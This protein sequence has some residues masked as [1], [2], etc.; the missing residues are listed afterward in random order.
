MIQAKKQPPKDVPQK[1]GGTM[2]P[3][4]GR[5]LQSIWGPNWTPVAAGLGGAYSPASVVS[6]M[7]SVLE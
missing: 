6:M 2:A 7:G 3:Q 5:R 1:L 4:L